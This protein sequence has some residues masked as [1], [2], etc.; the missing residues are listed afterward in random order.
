MPEWIKWFFDGL[1]TELIS[2]AIGAILG[3]IVGFRIGKH[4]SK[5]IQQQESGAESEQYQKGSSQH[6]KTNAKS[7]DVISSF[8]QKQTAGDKSRQTQIGGQEDV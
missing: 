4:K 1:G 3:G 6:K 2:L 7:E 5:F 8:A